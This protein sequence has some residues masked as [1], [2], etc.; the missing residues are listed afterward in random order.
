[1]VW[2]DDKILIAKRPMNGLLGGLWEFPGGKMQPKETAKECIMREIKEELLIDVIPYQHIDQVQHSYS[3]F[4]IRMDAYHCKYI[5]GKP[6][7][8]GC[9]DFRWIKPNKLKTLPFP[10]ANH[11]IFTKILNYKVNLA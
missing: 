2:H 3:H 9:S 7:P 5:K 1:M 8:L 10:R 4:S 6:K 11:K